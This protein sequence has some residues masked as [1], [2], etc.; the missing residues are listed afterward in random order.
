[1][2]DFCPPGLPRSTI[3]VVSIALATI[4]VTWASPCSAGWPR[5]PAES[6]S[7]LSYG[8]NVRVGLLSTPSYEDAVISHYKIQTLQSWQGLSP[9]RFNALA[10]APSG[11]RKPPGSA[12]VANER[13][14]WGHF[15]SPTY[16]N[17]YASR[18]PGRSVPVIV[19]GAAPTPSGPLRDRHEG[20]RTLR[21][22]R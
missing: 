6:S 15:I 21:G 20:P 2:S 7:S 13:S 11:R 8:S 18:S 3:F 17:A 4:G 16:R 10:G 22:R 9:C 1:M 14:A 5:R 12:M 19:T